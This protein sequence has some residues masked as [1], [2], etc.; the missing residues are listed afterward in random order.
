[1]K[2]DEH[3]CACE[4]QH[5]RSEPLHDLRHDLTGRPGAPTRGHNGPQ[6]AEPSRLDR[7]LIPVALD[8]SRKDLLE[9]FRASFG[10]Y[11]P[12]HPTDRRT[13]RPPATALRRYLDSGEHPHQ[14]GIKTEKVRYSA[15][16]DHSV[17]LHNGVL[18]EREFDHNC[19]V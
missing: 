3:L 17:R 12:L 11:T 16:N 5:A 10:P 18:L 2:Q 4:P 14:S 7:K 9:K 6:R 8:S 13:D 1:M 15:H 19:P